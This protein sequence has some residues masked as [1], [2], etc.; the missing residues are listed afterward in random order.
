M[1]SKRNFQLSPLEVAENM[2]R[3]IV[4]SHER[5]YMQQFNQEIAQFSESLMCDNMYYSRIPE[6]TDA[7]SAT[8]NTCKLFRY[9]GIVRDIKNPEFYVSSYLSR[10]V[11][12][13]ERLELGKYRDSI[14]FSSGFNF[15]METLSTM[16][17]RYF[18][19][20]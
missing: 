1:D 8:D 13:S 18:S 12:G 14:D 9:R 3:K 4:D 2:F 15:E 19:Y 16:D 5:N 20:T 6:V 7:L 17:E 11:D 10:K